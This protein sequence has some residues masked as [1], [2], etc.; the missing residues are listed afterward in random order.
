MTSTNVYSSN[1]NKKIRQDVSTCLETEEPIC[2]PK[3]FQRDG[4][5]VGIKL[6]KIYHFSNRDPEDW[7]DHKKQKPTA[8]NTFPVDSQVKISV[9]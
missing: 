6:S 5:L 2:I 1:K 4:L 9:V 8:P 3:C 7:Y